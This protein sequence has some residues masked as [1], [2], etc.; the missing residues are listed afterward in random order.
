MAHTCRYCG[1]GQSQKLV[2]APTVDGFEV[3]AEDGQRKKKLNPRY[4]H[5]YKSWKRTSKATRQW[6]RHSA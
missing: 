1:G 6:E 2:A 3:L 5:D 4:S